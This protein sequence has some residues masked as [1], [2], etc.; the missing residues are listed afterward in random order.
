MTPDKFTEIKFNY[1]HSDLMVKFN[2]IHIDPKNPRIGTN[3]KDDQ[4]LQESVLENGLNMQIVIAKTDKKGEYII[5]FGH[6]RYDIFVEAG[7]KNTNPLIP[8]TVIMPFDDPDRPLTDDEIFDYRNADENYQS[9]LSF[10]ERIVN[11]FQKTEEK[12]DAGWNLT[13]IADETFHRELPWL[14]NNLNAFKSPTIRKAI[15][16]GEVTSMHQAWNLLGIDAEAQET[17]IEAKKDIKATGMEKAAKL[18]REGT[19]TASAIESVKHP[20]DERT[21]IIRT[22]PEDAQERLLEATKD[23][24]LHDTERVVKQVRMGVSVAEAV[25]AVELSRTP[26]IQV[27]EAEVKERFAE[28]EDHQLPQ[29]EQHS[30]SASKTPELPVHEGEGE[31]T[32]EAV[33]KDDDSG[34]KSLQPS[35]P[36]T[37]DIIADGFAKGGEKGTE[38]EGYDADSPRATQSPLPEEGVTPDAPSPETKSTEPILVRKILKEFEAIKKLSEPDERKVVSGLNSDDLK[39]AIRT[40][41]KT[42]ESWLCLSARLRS[43]SNGETYEMSKLISTGP[44]VETITVEKIIASKE[45]ENAK[46]TLTQ[47]KN[48]I[49]ENL[50][51]LA[52]RGS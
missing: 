12:L 27:K 11:I 45:I 6:R 52:K 5:V 48:K 8:C 20:E 15:E 29:V 41:R 2:S 39:T 32:E 18:V 1:K 33:E 26:E 38:T 9:K 14:T 22:A 44:W 21:L 47:M 23:M 46:S 28:G 19:E 16:D 50:N 36:E 31:T 49:D 13:R 35:S 4:S 43:A 3:P 40:S 7:Y 51:L 25:R 34:R 37:P 42:G 17:L 10:H 24:D 30:P